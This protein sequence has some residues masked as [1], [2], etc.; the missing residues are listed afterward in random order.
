MGGVSVRD[1]IRDDGVMA[2]A[3]GAFVNRRQL[4]AEI[5]QAISK[6]GPEAHQ[7]FYRFEDDSTGEP[8]IFFRVVLSDEAVQQSTLAKTTGNIMMQLFDEIEPVAN[9]GL[10]AY[11]NFRSRS[12]QDERFDPDWT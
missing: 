5:Q 2:M 12:E 11:F 7:V 3:T 6:L 8:S 10:H 9:W 4:E 1:E